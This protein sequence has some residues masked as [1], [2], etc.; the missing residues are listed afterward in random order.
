MRT[1][2]SEKNLVVL[3]FILV[4]VVFTIAQSE[5]Q[6]MGKVNGG[7]LSSAHKSIHKNIAALQ[8]EKPALNQ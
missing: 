8:S 1:Y 5:T 6:K 3:L 7:L 2:F 4:L